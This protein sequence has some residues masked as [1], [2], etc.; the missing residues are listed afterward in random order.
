MLLG[1]SLG[2]D[3]L[4][5]IP[6]GI[7]GTDPWGVPPA[8]PPGGPVGIPLGP[9]ESPWM[10]PVGERDPSAESAGG[11]GVDQVRRFGGWERAPLDHCEGVGL[12]N[13]SA[14]VLR[15]RTC[16]RVEKAEPGRPNTL[17]TAMLGHPRAS[18]HL[19]H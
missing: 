6:G 12:L 4:R 10:V 11:I 14:R 2:G 15:I 18:G 7:L 9:G 17:R 3:P 8:D 13:Y 16:C 19:A 5:G 1:R